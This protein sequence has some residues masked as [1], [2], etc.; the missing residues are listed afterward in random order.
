MV[1]VRILFPSPRAAAS[2][3]QPIMIAQMPGTHCAMKRKTAPVAITA[4]PN[5][6]PVPVAMRVALRKLRVRFHTIERSTRPPSRGKP[7]RMLNTA[8]RTLAN[9]R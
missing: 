8:S 2:R 3:N 4:H 9:A 1:S 5:I 7:G 6:S